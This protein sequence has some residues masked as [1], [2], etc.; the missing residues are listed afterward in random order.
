MFPL[1]DENPVS[2]TPFVTWAVIALC[3]LAYF[4]IPNQ[5]DSTGA[6]HLEQAAIPCELSTGD[7]LSQQE[8]SAAQ[9]PSPDDDVCLD[10]DDAAAFGSKNVWVA[11]IASIFLHGGILH[12][13]GNMWFLWIFGNNVEDKLG[14][15]GYAAFYL[16]GGVAATVG[17]VVAQP[18]SIIPVVGASGA[19]AAVMG[20][21]LAWFPDAP[22]RTLL[23]LFV[24][25]IRA[26]WYLAG[27]F[28]L[29]FFTAPDSQVAWVAH[30]AGFVFGLVVG[31]IVRIVTRPESDPV[32]VTQAAWD[33]TGG[34]GRGPYRHPSDFFGR[35]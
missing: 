23:F 7:A 3:V 28:V 6:F 9:T 18:D 11:A 17:H 15:V 14:H 26:R 5:F 19:I 12:L 2:I 29:Q 32:D 4:A 10:N 22:I 8:V 21:Y 30:V 25:D 33:L 13:G 34:A 20:A 16:V 35:D 31:A 24:L 27:W 1:R